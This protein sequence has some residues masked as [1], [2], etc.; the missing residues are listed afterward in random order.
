VLSLAHTARV[1]RALAIDEDGGRKIAELVRRTELPR[2]T[3]TRIVGALCLEGLAFR[4]KGLPRYVLGPLAFELGLAAGRQYPLRD[5]AAASL[6]RLAEKTEDTCFLMV[7]SGQDA[8]CID[9]RGGRFPVKALTIEIGNRRPLGAAAASLALLMN[10][11]VP[12]QE[13]YITANDERLQQYG[14]LT[15]DAVRQMLN[16]SR[17]LG[18]ALNNNN[19]IAEVSAVGVAIPTSVGRPFAALSVSALSSRMMLGQRFRKIVGWMR[20]EAS[21]I[22]QTLNKLDGMLFFLRESWLIVSHPIS[23]ARMP[24]HRRVEGLM[25]WRRSFLEERQAGTGGICQG[26]Q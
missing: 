1:L 12:E 23:A 9:R 10:L 4:R 22:A 3:V 15:G 18:F 7:R 8:V 26:L 20:A 6:D 5:I 24:N 2:A 25:P 13:A 19:I 14:F 16:R 17:E 21:A 11:P